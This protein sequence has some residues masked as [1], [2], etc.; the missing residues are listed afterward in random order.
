MASLLL[1]TIFLP[2]AGCLALMFAPRLDAARARMLAL[3]VVLST[4]AL[5]LILLMGFDVDHV[6]PQFA[7]GPDG[8]PYGVAWME[9]LGVRFAAGLDGVSLWL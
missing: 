5:S 3:V 8:G 2:L 9:N 4:L 6:G 7:V 1:L